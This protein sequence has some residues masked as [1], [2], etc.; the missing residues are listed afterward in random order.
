[1][2]TV[3]ASADHQKISSELT[4]KIKENRGALISVIVQTE[5]GLQ[6]KHKVYV[7]ESGG[8]LKHELSLI[9]GFSAEL[10][11]AAINN[12][13]LE[14]DIIRISYDSQVSACLDTAAESINAPAA[15][16]SG[17]TGKGVTVAVVDTGIYPHPD[18]LQPVNRIIAFK[19]FV[20]K[21]TSP[22]DDNGHGTHVAG[23]IAGN[24]AMSEGRYKGIAP[25]ADLVGVKVLDNT[26][27]GSTSNVIAGIE[28]VVKNM[29]IYNIKVLN[30]SLGARTTESHSTDPLSQAAEAARNAGLVVV[31][32]AGNDGANPGSIRTPGTIQ[33]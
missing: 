27:G 23:I 19:D 17:L 6:E 1:M 8:R 2:S 21:K 29:S 24:G 7:H 30:L 32:A 26:G 9:R 5:N 22:Y 31:A 15:W 25:E 4:Q 28:W 3:P 20:N 33:I 13:A 10:P 11:A 14:K 16:A 12:L 18:L